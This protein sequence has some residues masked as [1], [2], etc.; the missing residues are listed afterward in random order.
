MT[1]APEVRVVALELERNDGRWVV[2]RRM[3]RTDGRLRDFYAYLGEVVLWA[4][5]CR[6]RG[7]TRQESK[8][9]EREGFKMAPR[10]GRVVISKDRN[11]IWI[12]VQGEDR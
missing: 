11:R 5:S 12:V 6:V 8:V 1:R 9:L 4:G 7:V 10:V 3:W 2:T